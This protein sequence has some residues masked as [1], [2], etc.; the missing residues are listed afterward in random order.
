MQHKDAHGARL[1]TEA[2]LAVA[3]KIYK[4]TSAVWKSSLLTLSR[5]ETESL[6]QKEPLF[7]NVEYF[8]GRAR[9]YLSKFILMHKIYKWGV[10]WDMQHAPEDYIKMEYNDLKKALSKSPKVTRTVKTNKSPVLLNPEFGYTADNYKNIPRDVIQKRIHLLNNSAEFL[11]RINNILIEQHEE[12]P[13]RTQKEDLQP[14]ETLYGGGFASIE[15][16]QLMQKF[17]N[18]GWVEKVKLIDKFSDDRFSLFASRIIYEESPEVLPDSI[19]NKVK[20]NIAERIFST[21]KKPWT[22]ISEFYKSI[23]DMRN[24]NE[25]DEKILKKLDEYNDFVMDI[26]KK[27]ESFK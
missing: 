9:I 24:K 2:C 21:E 27:Y 1:D 20:K 19:K 26:E 23:D 22:T 15:D 11:E 6:L 12:R 14:E 16:N 13:D 3:K 18:S 7:C 8:Y 5:A 25:N 10:C 17:H 4:K